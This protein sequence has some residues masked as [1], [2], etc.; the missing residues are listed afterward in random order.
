MEISN[1]PYYYKKPLLKGWI[2]ALLIIIPFFIFTGVF[3]IIGYILLGLNLRA[4]PSF[5]ETTIIQGI[6]TVGTLL[7]VFIFTRY[8]DRTTFKSIGFQQKKYITEILFGIVTGLAIMVSGFYIL[9]VLDEIKVTGI[10][11]NLPNLLISIILFAFVAINEEILMRGYILNNFLQSMNKYLA[12]VLSSLIFSI[13]HLLNP[14]FDLV[15]FISILLAGILLGISYIYTKSLWFPIVLHFSWNF[16]Q[17]TIFGFK[18]S[19]KSIYSVI[20]QEPVGNNILNGGEFGFEGSILSQIF[21]VIAILLIWWFM[22]KSK[23]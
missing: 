18:V 20:N 11:F 23:V 12:L 17:G 3:Q 21:I 7:L 19:G 22:R 4:K 13:L 15:S 16:F 9:F 6:S 8:L 5:G 1:N 2:R 10:D 14:N